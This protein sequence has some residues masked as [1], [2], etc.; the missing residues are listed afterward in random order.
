MLKKILQLLFIYFILSVINGYI[1]FFLNSHFFHL[2]NNKVQGLSQIELNFLALI[3]APIFETLFFQFL[4]YT[5]FKTVL[6]IKNEVI[7][8]ILMSL[9][10]SSA[11][12]Y[13]W[14]YM[15]TT[16][17]GGILLNIFYTSVL[18]IK[19]EK[20]AILFTMLFHFL[21]NLYGFLFVM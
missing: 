9:V 5:I 3:I 2:K 21:Y 20:Y 7:I 8:I 14:L 15:C 4:L 1:F 11:H 6:K 13:H 16:F 19:D 17:V 18:K 12:H 10:F